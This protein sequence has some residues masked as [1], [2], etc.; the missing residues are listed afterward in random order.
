MHNAKGIIA[1]LKEYPKRT[2][3]LFGIGVM[4]CLMA[5]SCQ[6]NPETRDFR[7]TVAP[8]FRLADLDGNVFHLGAEQGKMILIIFTT[9]WCPVCTDFVPLYKKIQ[10]VYGKEEK[11]VM[12][13]IDIEESSD[14]VRAFAKANNVSHRILLDSEGKVR[15]DYNIMGVPSF[16]L[17]D[18]EGKI[19]SADIERILDILQITFGPV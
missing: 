1:K 16:I 9:T 15:K 8:D 4:F 11:F 18:A 2:F 17:V 12:V 19:L 14:R 10:E 3:L 5:L 13:N 6:D 7:G